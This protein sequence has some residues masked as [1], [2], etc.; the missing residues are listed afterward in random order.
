M[1]KKRGE[2]H[3]KEKNH[4]T[5][6]NHG[7]REERLELRHKTGTCQQ[8]QI[9]LRPKG[10]LSRIMTLEEWLIE[11]QKERERK[12]KHIFN[13]TFREKWSFIF[14]PLWQRSTKHTIH[15]KN[16]PKQPIITI[17]Q[18]IAEFFAIKS[19]PMQTNHSF[20]SFNALLQWTDL[21]FVKDVRRW[22]G[23]G[24][25][26]A[27]V[28]RDQVEF[29]PSVASSRPPLNIQSLFNDQRNTK[30]MFYERIWLV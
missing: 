20:D 9:G 2:G 18:I 30:M 7:W 27:R 3:F 10:A 29:C 23:E 6:L 28:I 5:H 22:L 4:V 1:A 8:I 12:Q 21:A 16:S 26:N 17:V 14:E 19:F 24:T 11:R 15:L 13:R 25:E